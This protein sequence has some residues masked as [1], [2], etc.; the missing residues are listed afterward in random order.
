MSTKRRVALTHEQRLQVIRESE[1]FHTSSRKI[2]EKYGVGKTQIDRILKRK[3]ENLADLEDNV[4]PERKRQRRPTGN[5]E[6][7]NLVWEFF[8]DASSRRVNLSGPLLKQKALDFASDFGN[9]TFK[10]S[11]GWL[12]SFKSRHNI[13]FGTMSGERGDVDNSVVDNWRAK[14]PIICD[15]YSDNDIF[16]M[17]ETG[18]FYRDSTKNTLKVKGEEC[19]GGKRSKERITVALCSSLKGEK[20]PAL[21]IG[22]AKQPRCFNK[23][24]PETLPVIYRNN[25]KAWMNSSL[26]DGWLNQVNRKMK[27]QNRNI[28]LFLDNAPSH[29][30]IQPSNVKLVFFP[31]NTTS[32]CQPMD[33]GIIQTL[34]LKYRKRQLKHVIRAMDKDKTKCGTQ[35]L[36]D[37]TLLQ[38]IYWIDSAW[39]EVDVTTITKCFIKCGFSESQQRIHDD[40]DNDDDNDDDVPLSVLALSR[41]LFD[42]DFKD[43][44][45]IDQSMATCDLALTDWNK[46]AKDILQDITVDDPALSDDDGDDE[47]GDDEDKPCSICEGEFYIKRLRALAISQGKSKML[48]HVMGVDECLLE[49]RMD[50][51]EG[52]V[53]QSKISDFFLQK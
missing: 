26:F 20:L 37:I 25:R 10:A 17:D 27:R 8:K 16:N 14:L 45:A 44:V 34:K 41:D 53:Q 23:I 12:D 24:K 1:K 7:N 39:K 43:L 51:V 40:D 29:P 21:V 15:G 49:M 19:A 6:I 13:V 2:A 30:K 50:N 18:L 52:L 4:A 22:K 36:K 42:C 35:L 32:K 33:Q 5:E 48:N 47:Q 38:A 28:L 9:T 31:A 11:N 3:S 46:D